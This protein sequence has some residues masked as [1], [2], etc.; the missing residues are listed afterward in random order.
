MFTGIVE[1]AGRVVQV[2][3]TAAGI[4]FSIEAQL[5]LSGTKTGDSIAVNG[6]CLTVVELRG[7]IISFDL[8]RETWNRTNF[9][10]LKP[11]SLVNLERSM[12]ADGRIHGHFVTGHIDGTGKI[13]AFEQRGA[14]WY[15]LIEAPA[16]LQRYVV[17]QGSIALDGISLTLA[18]VHPDSF[19][20]WI[21]PHTYS[22]TA[23][24]D[25]KVGSLVNLEAD[26]IAKYVG[27]LLPT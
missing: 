19:A 27:K 15:L 2:Q 11:G 13:V 16:E 23:L 18:E 6:C 4:R 21:I 17:S 5:I 3:E 12:A 1:E 20:I 9:H 25:R 26:L 14:D 22:V 7:N 8:L 24:R 10:S